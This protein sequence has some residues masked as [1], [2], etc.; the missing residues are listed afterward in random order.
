[1]LRNSAFH[2]RSVEFGGWL[3]FDVVFIVSTFELA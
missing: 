3:M 2:N 1:M